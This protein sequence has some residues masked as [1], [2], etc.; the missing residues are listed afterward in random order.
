[1][2]KASECNGVLVG[3]TGAGNSCFRLPNKIQPADAVEYEYAG[4]ACRIRLLGLCD[5]GRR[6]AHLRV[7][8]LYDLLRH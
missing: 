7:H 8:H 4:R 5:N 1:M 2:K 6:L 3:S